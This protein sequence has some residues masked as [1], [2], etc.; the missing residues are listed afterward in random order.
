M[1]IPAQFTPRNII[2][3]HMNDLTQKPTG[4]WLPAR[5]YYPDEICL[6]HRLK[7]AWGVFTG[8]FDVLDWEV[9]DE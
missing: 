8:K 7:M 6:L 3:H 1:R 4:E 9:S 2:Q 5:P